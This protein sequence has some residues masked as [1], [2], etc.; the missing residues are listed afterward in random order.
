MDRKLYSGNMSVGHS[1]IDLESM[2][3]PQSDYKA[4]PKCV[5][6]IRGS[7]VRTGRHLGTKKVRKQVDCSGLSWSHHALLLSGWL[8]WLASTRIHT[9]ILAMG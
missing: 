3:M 1:K 7:G 8:L 6:W 9:K 5:S 2:K 4:E